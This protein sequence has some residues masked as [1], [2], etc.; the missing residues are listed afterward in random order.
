[1]LRKYRCI[2]PFPNTSMKIDELVEVEKKDDGDYVI[3][4]AI[5]TSKDIL[6]AHFEVARLKGWQHVPYSHSRMET[7]VSCPKK[8]QYQYIIRPER[9]QVP[10]PILEKG[11]L[12]HG[13]L[14]YDVTNN[15]D[16]FALD[17]EF[18]ALSLE[19]ASAIT[20]QALVFTET[21][22]MYK[23]IKTTKGTLVSEQEMMLGKNMYPIDDESET[24]IRGFIDL[25]I[26]D[27][28]GSKCF[29]YDWKTGGKSK[30][31]LV[32]WP[33]SKDQLELYAIWAVEV[34][35]VDFVE[36][37]FVYVEHDHMAKYVFTREQIPALKKKFISK[38]DRIEKD[39]SF[40]QSLGILCAWCDFRELCLGIS[41]TREPRSITKEEI[42]EAAKKSEPKPRKNKSNSKNRAF[43]DKIKKRTLTDG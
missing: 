13:V 12:W 4:G 26:Y 1:M 41:A 21:S 5:G 7:W 14:E 8:F 17:D 20:E 6:D 27:E 9:V 29:I 43:L 39:T 23:K 3:D 28:F 2:K 24:L 37:A 25:M 38:I 36:T 18:K 19:D 34:F 15:L 11:T 22:K 30:E 40:K 31:N 32:K 42:F 16:N 35:D 10:N 33:K